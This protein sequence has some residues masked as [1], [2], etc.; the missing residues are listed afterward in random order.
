[1]TSSLTHARGSI[2]RA[3]A[4][5]YL[6]RDPPGIAGWVRVIE[7]RL[8]TEKHPKLWSE[9]LTRMPILFQGNH[10]QATELF[11]RV[12]KA[13]PE[14]LH[15][16]FA[17]NAIAHV[18]RGLDPKEIG[19]EWL[20]KL[21]ADGLSFCRQAYG[22]LLPLYNCCH[23]DLRS[24]DRIAMHLAE[25]RQS[26][27]DRGLAYAATHLGRRDAVEKWQRAFLAVSRL[28]VTT[29]F[30]GQLLACSA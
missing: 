26:D 28:L 24:A 4:D 1:M 16:P 29:R 19:E 5:G 25:D 21:L 3:I 22:E 6:K 7:S 30:K 12:I 13:T 20:D 11:D 27:I 17:L 8:S 9:T 14:V 2:M 23:Q 10:R 18:M 15:Y